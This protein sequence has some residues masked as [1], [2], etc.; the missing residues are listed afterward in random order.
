MARTDKT[1]LVSPRKLF[2]SHYL[3]LVK[4][5]LAISYEPN[6][7]WFYLK[8]STRHKFM[9]KRWLPI[10]FSI[11]L[12]SIPL[13]QFS[14]NIYK[15]FLRIILAKMYD[16]FLENLY[17]W[18]FT[19]VHFRGSKDSLTYVPTQ[20]R[21]ARIMDCSPHEDPLLHLRIFPI[22]PQPT[23]HTG[24]NNRLLWDLMA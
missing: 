21:C 24:V 19:E 4:A 9:R 15:E 10:Q 23:S 2:C 14:L 13:V 20:W 6:K 11:W 7:T 5:W 16:G 8:F 22:N 17:F 18:R 3:N 1:S 12:Q